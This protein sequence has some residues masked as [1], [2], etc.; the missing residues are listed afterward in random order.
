M[1]GELQS[2]NWRNNDGTSHNVVEIKARRI[3]FLNRKSTSTE[4]SNEEAQEESEIIEDSVFEE[5]SIND[6]NLENN[7]DIVS[8]KETQEKQEESHDYDFGYKDLNL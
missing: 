5:N 8:E 1:D 2:R 4:A 6:E 3:Q 7:D